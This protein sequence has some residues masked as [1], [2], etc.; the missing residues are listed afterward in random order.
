MQSPGR[1][2]AQRFVVAAMLAA[3]VWWLVLAHAHW[4]VG[5]EAPLVPLA[6]PPPIE[7]QVVELPPAPRASETPQSNVRRD[8]APAVPRSVP[9][10]PRHPQPAHSSATPP[11]RP[12]RPRVTTGTAATPA[13][14]DAPAPAAQPSNDTPAAANNTAPPSDTPRADSPSGPVSQQARLLS[15][16]LPEVPDDLRE[17]GYRA[18]AVARFSVHADGSFEVE[19]LKPTQYPR[20]NQILLATL[21]QWRFF[22]AMEDGRPVESHQ[23]VRVH[24]N[25]D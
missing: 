19:L 2:S 4:L 14:H 5:T 21:R 15:Q 13:T 22:P 18:V 11:P 8:E 23:D 25:V 7:L 1:R 24:F 12:A 16:P 17:Q 10:M 9:P 20:L 3:A 6:P